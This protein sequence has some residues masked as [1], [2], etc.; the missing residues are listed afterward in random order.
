MTANERAQ[1]TPNELL[2]DAEHKDSGVIMALRM[3]DRDAAA[4]LTSERDELIARALTI[5]L[6]QSHEAWAETNLCPKLIGCISE[7]LETEG[8]PRCP[9]TG[10]AIPAHRM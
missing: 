2:H 5:D 1:M 4:A 7:M 6:K 9:V 10:E 3:G 8:K